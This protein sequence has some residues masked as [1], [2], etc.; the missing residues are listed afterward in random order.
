MLAVVC[1][2]PNGVLTASTFG[3]SSVAPFPLT[4]NPELR[5]HQPGEH[6]MLLSLSDRLV[7]TISLLTTTSLWISRSVETGLAVSGAPQAALEAA[8]IAMSRTTPAPSVMLTGPS[9][10]SK[11]TSNG[12]VKTSCIIGF[13]IVFLPFLLNETKHLMY[14]V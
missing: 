6:P 14:T 7:L 8:A 3:G 1:M 5:T 2:P 13:A 9:T 11:Y 4:S 12:I 10:L